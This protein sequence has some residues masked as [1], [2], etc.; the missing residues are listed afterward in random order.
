[1]L[2]VVSHTGID[3]SMTH[4]TKDLFLHYFGAS[5]PL[6]FYRTSNSSLLSASR[7]FHGGILIHRAGFSLAGS[8]L[9]NELV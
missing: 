5:D 3:Y 9:G 6:S 8:V 1:M 7:L 2:I 4:L